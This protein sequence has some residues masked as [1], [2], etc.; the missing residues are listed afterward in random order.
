MQYIE[1]SKQQ[2]SAIIWEKIMINLNVVSIKNKGFTLIEI[3]IALALMVLLM[4]VLIPLYFGAIK[5]YEVYENNVKLDNLAE[6]VK[7]TYNK[8]AM[9]IDSSNYTYNQVSFNWTNTSIIGQSGQPQGTAQ[10][11]YTAVP[12]NPAYQ[13]G[14]PAATLMSGFNS[15]ASNA[16]ASPLALATDGYGRPFIVFVS[17]Q[18]TGEYDGYQVYY[19][20]I[21]FVSNSGGTVA[22]GV[23]KLNSATKF[24]CEQTTSTQSNC[25]LS[26]AGNDKG[27]IIS[28]F[29]TQIKLLSRTLQN[30][31]GLAKAYETFYTSSYLDNT[32]RDIADDY[33]FGTFGNSNGC[34]GGPKVL[35]NYTSASNSYNFPGMNTSNQYV[36]QSNISRTLPSASNVVYFDNNNLLSNLG[37][38][39]SSGI[40][41]WGYQFG[42][43]NSRNGQVTGSTLR[44]SCNNPAT[45]A[46]GIPPYTAVI[47]SWAP[48]GVLL[49]KSVEGIY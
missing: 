4:G 12:G 43:S 46:G 37:L 45:G 44:T 24:E 39:S 7:I 13:M 22:N 18:L 28:G 21:A 6:G 47:Y 16:G 41:A 42:F 48:G 26:L 23:P 2:I 27:I 15:I 17:P 34:N 9:S 33:F 35:V 30:M 31:N 36:N 5:F 32:N 14:N 3:V 25:T 29:G 8:D 19:H 11:Y 1:G 40:S 10:S 38:S 20:E 49:T